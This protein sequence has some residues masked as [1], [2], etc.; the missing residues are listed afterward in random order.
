MK[1][2]QMMALS[3]TTKRLRGWRSLARGVRRAAERRVLLA[4]VAGE[5]V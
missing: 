4:C 3:L 1:G 5:G 2:D